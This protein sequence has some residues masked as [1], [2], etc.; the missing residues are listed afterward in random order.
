MAFT[1]NFNGEGGDTNLSSH[2]PSGGTAWTWINESNSA[3]SHAIVKSDGM[4]YASNLGSSGSRF[5]CDDQGSIRHYVQYVLKST[6]GNGSYV[7]NCMST[8]PDLRHYYGVRVNTSGMLQLVKSGNVTIG[9]F[10]IGSIP[11]DQLIRYEFDSGR[12]K[13]FVAG[14][15][16]INVF[17]NDFIYG[18]QGVVV[19]GESASQELWLDNIEFGPLLPALTAGA[20]TSFS[21]SGMQP[22]TQHRLIV[23][24]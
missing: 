16:R 10:N 8:I 20:E 13:V 7:A 5:L 11:T 24:W 14:V 22:Q 19:R 6:L 18:G 12:H 4:L 15:E 2:T 17:D 3:A 9:S 1:D 21:P 23:K